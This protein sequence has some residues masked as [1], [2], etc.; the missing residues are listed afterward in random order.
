MPSRAVFFPW[1]RKTG[2]LLNF[3]LEHKSRELEQKS[4]QGGRWEI[5]PTVTLCHPLA[6][7]ASPQA[8]SLGPALAVTFY[9]SH[10][11][12]AMLDGPNL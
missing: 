3:Q 11:Q 6:S 12:L 4:P 10:L 1:I 5:H 8:A 2:C 9:Q 7:E